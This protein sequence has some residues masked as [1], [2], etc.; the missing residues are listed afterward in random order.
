[1]SGNSAASSAVVGTARERARLRS[2]VA[3]LFVLSLIA[4]VQSAG[5]VTVVEEYEIRAEELVRLGPAVAAFLGHRAQLEGVFRGGWPLVIDYSLRGEPVRLAITF[6]DA[7]P[8]MLEL[9]PTEGERKV[10]RTR[11]PKRLGK[12]L[13]SGTFSFTAVYGEGGTPA[14]FRLFGLGCGP[15]AVGSINIED[16]NFRDEVLD[17]AD[18]DTARTHY[19]PLE[20]FDHAQVELFRRETSPDGLRSVFVRQLRLRTNPPR[21]RSVLDIWNG[22]DSDGDP[23]QGLHV[24][25]VRVWSGVGGG[26]KGGSWIVAASENQLEVR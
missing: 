1:M 13:R 5:Q 23:S 15:R 24:F 7:D 4:C 11:V 10:F 3:G 26:K 22:R 16:V 12:G 9:A 6:R 19:R 8:L 18:Q 17:L 25:Q 20:D 2:I 14:G 21:G